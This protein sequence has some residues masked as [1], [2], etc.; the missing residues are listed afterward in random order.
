MYWPT[1]WLGG[2][3]VYVIETGLSDFHMMTVYFMKMYHRM[4][5]PK[6]SYRDYKKSR[7][8]D[9]LDSVKKFFPIEIKVSKMVG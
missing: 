6:I 9:L 5:S 8:K 7:N 3:E 4:L 1:F 2:P